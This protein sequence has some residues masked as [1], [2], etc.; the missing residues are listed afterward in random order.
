[1]KWD[2]LLYVCSGKCLDNWGKINSVLSEVNDFSLNGKSKDNATILNTDMS[3]QIS[4][5]LQKKNIFRITNTH[6]L[7]K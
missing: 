2:I 7:N 3:S 1:M 4:L 5:D 6:S